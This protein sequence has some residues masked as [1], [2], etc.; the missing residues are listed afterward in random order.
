MCHL[1]PVHLHFTALV[2]MVDRTS[3]VCCLALAVCLL[4]AASPCVRRANVN[5][6]QIRSV[7][8]TKLRRLV[9]E[10]DMLIVAM[11]AES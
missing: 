8:C 5:A 4:A 3:S 10:P 11:L 2:R 6:N 7:G 9:Y 1:S